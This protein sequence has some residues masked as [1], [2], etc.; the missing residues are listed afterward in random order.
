MKRGPIPG[1]THVDHVA[2][3]VPDLDA[4]VR[5][6]S[7]V[8][9]GKELYRLGPF[10]AA[11][12]PHMPDGRD[13]GEAHINVPGARLMIAM[14]QVGPNLMLELFRYEKPAD[15]ARI[16]PR[17]CDLG[18]HHIAF[19]VED[20]DTATSYLQEKGVRAMQGPIVLQ[21]GPCAG[22]RLNYFLDPWGNQLELVEYQKLPYM[23][24]VGPARRKG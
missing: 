5:F 21:E 7:E 8:I 1:L 16:P 12:L 3:T 18:G 9:G 13:W 23:T 20:L 14:L 6:Y 10:D 19:K 4:A 2:L 17:N 24:A 22:Q 15:A 11:E